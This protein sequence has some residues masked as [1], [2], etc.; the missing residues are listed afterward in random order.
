MGPV[1]S[2]GDGGRRSSA[3][4][5]QVAASASSKEYFMELDEYI[6]A[7]SFEELAG[8]DP[9]FKMSRLRLVSFSV[10]GTISAAGVVGEVRTEFQEERAKVPIH[11]VGVKV[12]DHGRGAYQPGIGR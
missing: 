10:C 8:C 9:Y 7:R 11:A 12:I 4:Q 1:R 6:S 2:S 5:P 3:P